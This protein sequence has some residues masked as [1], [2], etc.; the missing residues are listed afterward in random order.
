ML[1]LRKCLLVAEQYSAFD[2]LCMLKNEDIFLNPHIVANF[3]IDSLD[4]FFLLM[5]C[6]CVH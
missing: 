5:F 1:P 4:L 6:E 2:E 3:I